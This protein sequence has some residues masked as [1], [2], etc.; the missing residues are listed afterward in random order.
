MGLDTFLKTL[1]N[2]E[3][4]GG[5]F[6]RRLAYAAR[7]ADSINK[8]KILTAWEELFDEYSPENIGDPDCEPTLYH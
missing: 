8:E 2:M 1:T 3:R 6:T 4:H 5:E 7:V